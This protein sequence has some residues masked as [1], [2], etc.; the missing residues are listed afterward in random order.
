MKYIFRII[1]FYM[2]K[3]EIQCSPVKLQVTDAVMQL[4][5]CLLYSHNQPIL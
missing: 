5:F 2:F 4:F 3:K 1:T